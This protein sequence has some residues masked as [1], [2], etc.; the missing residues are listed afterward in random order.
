MSIERLLEGGDLRTAEGEQ[1][2]EGGDYQIAIGYDWARAAWRCWIS[3]VARL[4]V[5]TWARV[6]WELHLWRRT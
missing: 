2:W 6:V 4:S 1:G 5:Q 3:L